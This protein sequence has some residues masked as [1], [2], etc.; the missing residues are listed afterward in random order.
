VHQRLSLYR[1]FSI[2]ATE[3]HLLSLEEELRDRFGALPTEAQN[4]MWMIRI[5]QLLKKW[6]IEA[7]TVGPEKASL[8]PGA[9]SRLDPV[10]AIALISGQPGKYQLMPDSRF[11]AKIP[12]LSLRDLYFGL[13]SLFHELQP[14][15]SLKA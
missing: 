8:L 6:G 14:R 10:R 13:E 12:T 3:E 1:R 5:K 4:L 11:V 2:A 15:G 7:L 9:H